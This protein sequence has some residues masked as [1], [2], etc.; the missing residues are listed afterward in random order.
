M[1]IAPV[2]LFWKKKLFCIVGEFPERINDAQ[3]AKENLRQ[4][5]SNEKVKG[6]GDVLVAKDVNQGIVSL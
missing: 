1:I 4:A 3:T 5:M 6:F 2:Y